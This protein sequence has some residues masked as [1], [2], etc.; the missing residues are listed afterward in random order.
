MAY[1]SAI[2]SQAVSIISYDHFKTIVD[3]HNG[4]HRVHSFSRW[5]QFMAM[6]YAQLT[7][8]ESLRDLETAV[9]SKKNFARLGVKTARR[10]TISDANATRDWKIYRDLLQDLVKR[11]QLISPKHA[12][13]FK[14]RLRAL[15]ATT[16]KLCLKLFP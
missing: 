2:F 8:K 4:D 7:D 3:R 9:M 12:F 14:N 16:I 13:R 11:C 10:S 15:D 6:L 1:Y 5:A